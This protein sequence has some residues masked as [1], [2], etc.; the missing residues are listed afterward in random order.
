MTPMDKHSETWSLRHCWC[1]S[2]DLTTNN[3][4]RLITQ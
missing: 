2:L 3:Q 1:S 4:L